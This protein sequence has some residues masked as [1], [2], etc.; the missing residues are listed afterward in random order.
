MKRFS[1]SARQPSLSDPLPRRLTATFLLG[2]LVF[3][4][5]WITLVNFV[6]AALVGGG[7]II[8]V[9]LAAAASD[10]LEAILEAIGSVLVAVLAIFAALFA[11]VADIFGRDVINIARDGGGCEAPG[12]VWQASLAWLARRAPHCCHRNRV[13]RCARSRQRL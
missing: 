7:T 11:A 12:G 10:V 13:C 2:V 4:L 3:L 5:L 6:T 8:L 9:V 1:P